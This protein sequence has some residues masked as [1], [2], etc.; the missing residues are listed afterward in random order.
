MLRRTVLRAGHGVAVAAAA[1]WKLFHRHLSVV[2]AELWWFSSS[3]TVRSCRRGGAGGGRG[4]RGGSAGGGGCGSRS[5]GGRPAPRQWHTGPHPD[6]EPGCPSPASGH[7]AWQ[8]QAEGPRGGPPGVRATASGD[9]PPGRPRRLQVP[10][11]VQRARHLRWP[12]CACKNMDILEKKIEN[13]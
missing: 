6:P 5:G 12:D 7:C 13:N 8:A 10:P 2:R 4:R 11:P 9:G 1:V 3:C